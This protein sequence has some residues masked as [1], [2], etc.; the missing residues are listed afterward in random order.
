[1]KKLWKPLKINACE[2]YFQQKKA[3]I[4]DEKYDK[5]KR[6]AKS[7]SSRIDS[8]GKNHLCE[9]RL[10]KELEKIMKSL[11][12]DRQKEEFF[13]V[14]RSKAIEMFDNVSTMKRKNS[15][16]TSAFYQNP[17][18]QSEE[19]LE[20]IKKEEEDLGPLFM[21]NL[22]KRNREAIQNTINKMP[23]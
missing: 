5:R 11:K 12:W 23:E 9:P 19:E 10:N 8:G 13:K 22:N 15:L 3:K 14:E 21:L 6:K 17:K 1:M 2:Y 20:R 4:E 16:A 7:V 18:Y